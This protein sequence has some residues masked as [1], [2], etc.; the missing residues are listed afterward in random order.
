MGQNPVRDYDIEVVTLLTECDVIVIY[1]VIFHIYYDILMKIMVP[2]L[3][4]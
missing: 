1:F 3:R 2:L 4:F